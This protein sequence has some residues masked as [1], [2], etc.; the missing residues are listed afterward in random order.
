[1]GN[2]GLVT[3]SIMMGWSAGLNFRKDGGAGIPAGNSGMAS[4]MA[5]W[6]STA[7]PSISRARSNWSVML[8][9][10]VVLLEVIES[11]PAMLVNWRSSGVATAEAIVA[12]SPP[13]RLAETFSV[14]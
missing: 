12:G 2:E 4:A 10:P 8:V 11:R 6:T 5:V 1:M 9:L 7:A 13:G 14:G 3:A